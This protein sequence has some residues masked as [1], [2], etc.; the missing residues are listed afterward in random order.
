MFSVESL[1]FCEMVP[2]ASVSLCSRAFLR[3][4]IL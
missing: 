2:R 4:D 1:D 3:V